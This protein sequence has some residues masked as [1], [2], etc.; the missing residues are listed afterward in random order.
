M[1][2]SIATVIEKSLRFVGVGA[3]IAI[4]G[5]F[6]WSTYQ[7]AQ[8]AQSNFEQLLPMP[9]FSMESLITLLFAPETPLKALAATKMWLFFVMAAG[10]GWMTL[11]GARWLYHTSLKATTLWRAAAEKTN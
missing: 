11:L 5:I 9:E 8:A 3:N 7:F 10:C 2:K 6:A 4:L 1:S